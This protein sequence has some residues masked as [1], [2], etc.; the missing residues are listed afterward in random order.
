MQVNDVDFSGSE[1]V[2]KLLQSTTKTGGEVAK[3][4][5]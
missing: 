4:H 3:F 1:I 5:H 2:E